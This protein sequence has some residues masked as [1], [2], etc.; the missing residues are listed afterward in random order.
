MIPT[1]PPRRTPPAPKVEFHD[2]K[3][4]MQVSAEPANRKPPPLR[5]PPTPATPKI[6]TARILRREAPKSNLPKPGKHTAALEAEGTTR[7]LTPKQ[8]Q[9][10]DEAYYAKKKNT[11]LRLQRFKTGYRVTVDLYEGETHVGQKVYDKLTALGARER[12]ALHMAGFWA[13]ID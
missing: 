6:D 5:Q 8:S 1:T 4:E 13:V 9:T 2:T 3:A 7:T 12:V 11:G 10:P